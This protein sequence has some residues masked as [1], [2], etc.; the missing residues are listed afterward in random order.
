MKKMKAYGMATLGE[1]GQVVIPVQLR[2]AMKIRPQDQ[3]IIFADPGKRTINL[4]SSKDFS[5]FLEQAAKLMSKFQK[6]G[7]K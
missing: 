5:S 1:R 3:F 4:V 7:R 6:S 2:K